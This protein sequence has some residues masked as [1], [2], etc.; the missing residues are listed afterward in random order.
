MISLLG[1]TGIIGVKTLSLLSNTDL[2]I[3]ALTAHTNKKLLANQIIK[4]NPS[5]AVI[6]SKNDAEYLKKLCDKKKISTKILSGESGL[7]YVSSHKRVSHVLSAIVGA[8]AL[9]PTF[10]AVKAGKKI[11]LANKESLVMSGSL[12]IRTAKKTG[13]IIV[14]IDSEHNAI[15]QIITAHGSTYNSKN[16]KY[17]DDIDHLYIT[18][19]G[20]PFLNYSQS[21]LKRVT[22]SQAI[23]HPT[24]SMGK[25]ISID[26]ATMMNKGLE[27]IEAC[28]LFNLK[29][30]Q[31][32]ILIHPQSILHAMVHFCDGSIISHMS[33]HDMR[34]AINYALTWPERKSLK[35]NIKKLPLKELFFRKTKKNEFKC[36]DLCIKALKLGGSAPTILNAANEVAVENFLQN[37]IKFTD[38]PVIIDQA[39]K[40]IK[41]TKAQSIKSL[42]LCDEHTREYVKRYIDK[43][44]K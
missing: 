36:L 18:A 9:R 40:N 15:L 10:N 35:S 30:S 28:I 16:N 20:G 29:P 26:S 17:K 6:K 32:N 44:W 4:Y 7:T 12:M 3:F 34:I 33:A 5:Y 37:K 25:K 22:V 39:L 23:K 27:V 21:Q 24:W 14:P 11:L 41:I 31:I 42:L 38:I 2:K 8:A 19:S 1:S 43:K 13:A